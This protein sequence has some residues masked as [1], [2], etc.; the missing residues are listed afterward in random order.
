M[1]VNS[2]QKNCKEQWHEWNDTKLEEEVEE[3]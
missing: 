3:Y 1:D 2:K